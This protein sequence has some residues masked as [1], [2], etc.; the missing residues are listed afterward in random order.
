MTAEELLR[1]LTGVRW[2]MAP[3]GADAEWAEIRAEGAG[4]EGRG[5]SYP[6]DRRLRHCGWVASRR[7]LGVRVM[8][9]LNQ[10][11]P[12]GFAL[13]GSENEW[14]CRVKCIRDQ[15]GFRFSHFVGEYRPI[16]VPKTLL[17]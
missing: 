11:R 16:P 4:K 12:L 17:K 7:C 13:R 2:P 10:T 15:R 14:G 8:E 1:S 9:H 3:D 6:E 5:R